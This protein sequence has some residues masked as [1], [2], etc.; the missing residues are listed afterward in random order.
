MFGLDLIDVGQPGELVDQLVFLIHEAA[1]ILPQLLHLTDLRVDLRD[2]LRQAVNLVD[3]RGDG[4]IQVLLN[5]SQV[6]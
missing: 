2:L 5:T 1:R 3:R 6:L 4:L